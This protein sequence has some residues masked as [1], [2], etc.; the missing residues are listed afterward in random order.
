MKKSA[1][2]S[3]YAAEGIGVLP[4]SPMAR[5][6]LTRPWE[7]KPS[8]DRAASDE[9][10]GKLYAKTEEADRQ[11]VDGGWAACRSPRHSSRK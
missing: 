10:I 8:T 1:K 7:D 3:G 4:W 9:M 5:G 11:V 6:R 2:C